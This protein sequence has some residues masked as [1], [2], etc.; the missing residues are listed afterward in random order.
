MSSCESSNK[1]YVGDIGTEIILDAKEDI[2]TATT[3]EIRY[4]K[5]DGTTG[6]WTGAVYDTTKGRYVTVS[7][8]L[9]QAGSWY[10]QLYVVL[11]SWSGHGETVAVT[12]Y[13]L[14]H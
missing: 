2:S 11:P 6:A 5:P 10:L 7:G 1:V 4:K 3:V 8:D 12:I 13:E 9:D 14:F